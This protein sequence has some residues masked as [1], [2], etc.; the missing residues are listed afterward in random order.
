MPDKSTSSEA[1]VTAARLAGS[2]MERGERLASKVSGEA[3]EAWALA[4]KQL[5][6][7]VQRARQTP[8]RA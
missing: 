2:E 6:F 5:R 7:L 8:A 4:L 1:L 3:A